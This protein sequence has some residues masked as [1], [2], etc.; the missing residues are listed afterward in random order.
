[1]FQRN[2]PENENDFNDKVEALLSTHGSYTREYLVLKFWNSA[3]IPDRAQDNLLI[4]SKYLRGNTT[5]SK[6]TEGIVA[7]ITKMPSNCGAM[8]I[9]YDTERK[10]LD[11]KYF[12]E[13]FEKKRA[14]CFVRIYR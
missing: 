10:I 12:S 3:Y 4:E 8:F 11:D 1:M 14:E 2:K 6:I 7:D 9:V 13:E 5:P